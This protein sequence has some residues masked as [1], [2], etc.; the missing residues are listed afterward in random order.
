[1]EY[2]QPIA[3]V[4]VSALFPDAAEKV[5]FWKNILEGKDSMQEIPASHWRMEDY[6]HPAPAAADKICCKRGAFLPEI[7]FDPVKFAIPPNNLQA[8]DTCQLL[9]LI[10]AERVLE[11]ACRFQFQSIN[12]EK[13]SVILGVASTTELSIHLGG[14]IQRPFWARALREKGM[15]EQEVRQLCDRIA[16]YYVPWQENSFPGL[17][18][19][20]V[21]GRIANHFDLK[22][23]N[24]VVDAACASSLSAV[25]MA[26][27]ELWTG[28]SDLVITGGAD[29]MNDVFMYMCFSKTM[30]LSPTGDCRPFSHRADGTVLGEGIGMVALKRLSDAE[31]NGDP[32]YAVIKGL[33]SSSDG[34]S[35][36]VFAPRPEGQAI[37]LRRAYEAAGYGPDTVE[38][39]EAHGTG[40]KA[41]DAAEFEGLK[42]VF[43]SP[44]R[45]QWCALGSVKSQIGHTKAAAGTAGLIKAIMA[46][47]HKVLPGTIKVE[48]PNPELKI[49]DSPFYLNTESRPWIRGLDY[50]R[51]ASVSS[52]GFGGSNF[53][54]TLEE[55]TKRENRPYKLRT[56]PWE[57]F[58]FACGSPEELLRRGES[59]LATLASREASSGS[60][61]TELHKILAKQS[62]EEY[63]HRKGYRLA[64]LSSGPEE[65][66][67]KMKQSMEHIR[68]NPD[69]AHGLPDGIYYETKRVTGKVAFL[70]PGQGSQYVNM[71][72]DLAMHFDCARE[73][74]DRSTELGAVQGG[75]KLHDFVFPRPAFDEEARQL[76]QEELTDTR[77]AQPAI[78]AMSL[79]VL[80]ILKE[81]GQEADFVAGHSYGEITALASAGVL[82]EKEMLHIAGKR[83]ALMHEASGNKG[84]M[85][86][87]FLPPEQVQEIIAELKLP[88]VIAN[89]NSPEQVAVSG[90]EEEIS[91]LE[92]ALGQRGIRCSTLPVSAAF[93]S[94]AVE[95]A[96]EPFREF[97][98]GAAFRKSAVPVY[99]NLLGGPYP[100]EPDRVK[101]LLANQIAKPV[102]FADSICHMVQQGAE[103]FIEVGPG[104]VLTGLTRQCLAGK[105]AYAV[106]TDRKG[107]HGLL[108]LLHAVAYISV[109]GIKLDYSCLW[110]GY[111]F[112][113]DTGEEKKKAYTVKIN[114]ANYGKPHP[115]EGTA[116]PPVQASFLPQPGQEEINKSIN[117][118]VFTME[119]KEQQ[120]KRITMGEQEIPSSSVAFIQ[121]QMT[122]AHLAFQKAL[123]ESHR[124]YLEASEKLLSAL[125]GRHSAS[126]L[127]NMAMAGEEQQLLTQDQISVVQNRIPDAGETAGA[128]LFPEIPAYSAEKPISSTP[129]LPVLQSEGMGLA[130]QEDEGKASV[131]IRETVLEVVAEKTGYPVEMLDPELDLEAGLGIDS[132]KRVEILSTIPGRLP[133]ARSMDNSAMAGL[134]TLNE[135]ILFLEQKVKKK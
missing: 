60:S 6:Y 75:R 61:G 109:L 40:T 118:K 107:R 23:T 90:I 84:T 119:P 58:L 11:D 76:Q 9:A 71:G 93:H 35:K 27:L 54:V 74:W 56:M 41:G 115:P 80:A 104:G 112:M 83:G 88:V 116:V 128:V 73:V 96:V 123:T 121:E 87:V 47:H 50:P 13:T 42:H 28:K 72:K 100:E 78:G 126:S 94:A 12:K 34:K 62:Q 89:V 67:S 48:K 25:S 19:N 1:M 57:M 30:A 91:R 82:S 69:K 111:P 110:A 37:A 105:D 36:S 3:V 129:M 53:H 92:E 45:K 49:E 63:D 70:F 132:I 102:R 86:A 26:I 68:K 44:E 97:L 65:L 114:G 33:G 99:S 113:K 77:I 55:Y 108:S 124:A 46:L 17:L 52:F 127:E 122:E 24:T 64:I 5:A 16:A 81:L 8:T 135:I 4:G 21:A 32:I 101:E 18:G 29:A 39:M 131:S 10:V 14:R 43:Q 85:A 51:R 2:G 130:A 134:H 59:L 66:E 20:V 7:E 117:R 95:P 38:L 31:R 133:E 106:A 103:L 79:S 125:T 22:G 98:K 120:Q 15:G